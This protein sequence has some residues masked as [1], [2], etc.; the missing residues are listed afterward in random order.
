MGAATAG[1]GALTAVTGAIQT[2]DA[3][4]TKK[5]VAREI[6]NMKEVP[7][8]NIAD[9]MQVSTLGSDLQ[10]EEAARLSATQTSALQDG[11]TR[12]LLGGLGRVTARNQDVN[13][14]I[15]ANLDEQQKQIDQ[16]AA[17]DEQR[18]QSIKE[19]RQMNKLAALSSQYNAANQGITQGI[20]NVVQGAGTAGN[21]FSNMKSGAT[22]GTN[23]IDKKI[24]IDPTKGK[25]IYG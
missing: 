19:Q 5:K 2:F 7:L 18:I 10:R 4:A 17:Q 20:A 15:G 6:K 24:K 3:M 21:A 9:G 23:K 14:Q 25:D 13:A 22:E 11:G 1:A 16:V 12:A 8:T